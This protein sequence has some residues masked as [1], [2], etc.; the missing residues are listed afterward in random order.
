MS[1]PPV[2]QST[3]QPVPLMEEQD[4]ALER[5]YIDAYLQSRGYSLHA[6]HELPEDEARRLLTEASAYASTKL[7][8]VETR[9]HFMQEIHGMAPPMS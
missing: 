4:A 1:E 8:E 9:A 5:M 3:N 2:T 7:A 6:L